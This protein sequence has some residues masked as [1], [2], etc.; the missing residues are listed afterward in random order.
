MRLLAFYLG[1]HDSNLSMYDTDSQEFQY[2]KSERLFG[3]KRHRADLSFVA[4][5]C[6]SLGFIPDAVAYSDGNR[7][8]LGSCRP[9]ESIVD[10]SP[11]SLFPT[12]K[13]FIVDH[14]LAHVLSAWPLIPTE[15]VEYAIAIDGR[16]DHERRVSVFRSPANLGAPIFTSTEHR[17]CH[18]FD[19]IG[20][21]MGLEGHKADFAGK[22]MGAQAYGKA[23]EAFVVSQLRSAVKRDLFSLVERLDQTR[24][25]GGDSFYRF[26]N[27]GFRDWLA[28]VHSILEEVVAEVFAEHIPPLSTVVYAGG[29]ALNTVINDRLYRHY[30]NL[31][32]PPHSYDG[33]LSLGCLEALRN[34]MGREAIVAS[35]FPFFQGDEDMGYASDRVVREAANHL[36]AGK[37]LGWL[38][39]KGE[40]GPRALGHRS[41]LLNPAIPNGKDLLNRIKKREEWRP[42]A[43]SVLFDRQ[44]GFFCVED[45]LPYMLRSVQSLPTS[46]ELIP[47]VVHV[48]GTSRIQSVDATRCPGLETYQSLLLNFEQL[49]GLP[50]I[51]NTSFNPA[52]R[53]I[54]S[55]REAAVAWF[56]SSSIDVL[57]VGDELMRKE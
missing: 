57:V 8:G 37:V 43:P 23:D 2:L 21:T 22:I 30:P 50:A 26:E 47:A 6:E 9:T 28:S 18:L 10:R 14:H 19:L 4:E 56:R 12:A 32:I 34:V 39:G 49:T 11:L 13:C 17:V 46:K 38:Q 51:L 36:A 25:N 16:G 15:S 1:L 7:N 33:G 40:I 20:A 27:K 41:L 55:T 48:D 35:G 44:K 54:V 5:R 53:P 3:V 29:C 31:V 24:W 42:F 52:G 45:Y